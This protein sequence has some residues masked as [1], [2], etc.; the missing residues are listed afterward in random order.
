MQ[1]GEPP[2]DFP[3][4]LAGYTDVM[5]SDFVYA[6]TPGVPVCLFRAAGWWIAGL[7]D[8]VFCHELLLRW[9]VTAMTAIFGR[10][11]CLQ[12]PPQTVLY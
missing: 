12:P 6:K 4:K 1:V 3:F 5:P 9:P 2:K 10:Y 11:C 8:C 7:L